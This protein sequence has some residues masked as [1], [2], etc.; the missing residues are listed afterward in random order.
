MFP[1]RLKNVKIQLI[2][3]LLLF[4]LFVSIKDKTDYIFECL[5]S[6]IVAFFTETFLI[7][8][9]R[10]KIQ[11]TENSIITG[12]IVGLV[13]SHASILKLSFVSALSIIL[14]HIIRLRGKHLFNPAALGLLISTLFYGNLLDWKGTYIWYLLIPFG[15]YFATKVKRLEVIGAYFII[16]LILYGTQSLLKDMPLNNIFGFYSYF[17]IFIMLIEPKTSPITKFGKIIFGA[18]VGII[19]YIATNLGLKTDVELMGLLLMNTSVPI[20][21]KIKRK[22]AV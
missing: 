7:F 12:L 4:A 9:R 5:I 2:I 16:S 3:F 1:V 14:K 17:F 6:G 19:I 8:P 21:N 11:F 22:E 15:I 18:G 10:R 13:F 20:L